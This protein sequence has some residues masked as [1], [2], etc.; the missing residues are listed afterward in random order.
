[1]T[2]ADRKA[3]VADLSA[4]LRE[5]SM[6]EPFFEIPRP[7]RIKLMGGEAF[8]VVIERPGR[9]Y[10]NL[11]TGRYPHEKLCIDASSPPGV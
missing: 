7:L 5:L 1:M 4:R 3:L 11:L 6:A 10:I 9:M 2:P 8:L